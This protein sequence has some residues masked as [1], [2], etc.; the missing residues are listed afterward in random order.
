MMCSHLTGSLCG[1]LFLWWLLVF[2]CSSAAGEAGYPVLARSGKELSPPAKTM[3]LFD[4]NLP[5]Q[6]LNSAL[7]Q[8][9]IITG[10]PALFHSEMVNGRISSPVR[11]VYTPETALQILLQDTGLAV[12]K[13]ANGPDD[14]FVLRVV[15]PVIPRRVDKPLDF[16][17][18]SLV[19]VG[20]WQAVCGI[21]TGLPHDFR[22][23][24]SV[25][26]DMR[27]NIEQPRLITTTGDAAR[28]DRLLKALRT[29]HIGRPPS[30]DMAQPLTMIILPRIPGKGPRCNSDGNPT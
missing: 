11:G 8:Y 25:R 2:S 15:S 21:L 13:V 14:V 27:G 7:N 22:L 20:I 9:A 4:F 12:E 17:Y 26:V 29:L 16:A 24:I 5:A 6:P 10:R 28:D 19:Q 30:T 3:V 18:G 23:L 1:K